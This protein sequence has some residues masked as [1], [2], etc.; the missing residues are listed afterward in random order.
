MHC[1]LIHLV[2]FGAGTPNAS[3]PYSFIPEVTT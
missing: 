1:V 3:F 2:R